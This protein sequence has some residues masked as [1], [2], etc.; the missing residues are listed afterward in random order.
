MRC[1]YCNLDMCFGCG[2]AHLKE[3]PSPK[4]KAVSEQLKATLK[5]VKEQ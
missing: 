1:N 4:S 3:C 5:E 2:L